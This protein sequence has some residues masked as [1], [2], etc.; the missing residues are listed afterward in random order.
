[1]IIIWKDPNMCLHGKRHKSDRYYFRHHYGKQHLVYIQKEYTDRPTENQKASRNTFTTIRKE[2]ARQLHDPVLKARWQ[3]KF[4][5]DPQGYKFLHTYV[6]AQLKAGVTLTQ[7]TT[8]RDVPIV[9][10]PHPQ[11]SRD[12]GPL[13]LPHQQTMRLPHQQTISRDSLPIPTLI[14]YNHTILPF[15]LPSQVPKKG[16]QLHP[17]NP[18]E[19]LYKWQ[20]LP[21]FAS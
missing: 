9:H 15:F 21:T 10:L 8:S 4:Q 14:I 5:A 3:T 13:R 7:P 17:T 19:N 16:K 2:V 18:T 11:S 20:N 12:A 1:M 6:Y